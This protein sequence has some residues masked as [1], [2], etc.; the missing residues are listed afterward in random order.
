MTRTTRITLES[1]SNLMRRRKET[2][3]RLSCSKEKTY[4][5]RIDAMTV[6]KSSQLNPDLKKDT[7]LAARRRHNSTAKTMQKTW[8][9]TMKNVFAVCGWIPHPVLNPTSAPQRMPKYSSSADIM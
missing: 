1:L 7:P 4:N 8:L 6:T 3:G 5:S 2:L 9:Q